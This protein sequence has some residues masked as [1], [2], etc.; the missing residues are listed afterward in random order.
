LMI[1]MM[2]MLLNVLLDNQIVKMIEIEI[3]VQQDLINVYVI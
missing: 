1:L 3:M 2:N